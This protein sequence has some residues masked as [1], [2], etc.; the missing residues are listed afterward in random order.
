MELCT[1][2]GSP[3]A[4]SYL[5]LAE[6]DD[7]MP[8]HDPNW[9]NRNDTEKIILIRRAAADV[10]KVPCLGTKLSFGQSLE[11][12]RKGDVLV[13]SL[14]YDAGFSRSM[15]TTEVVAY[16]DHVTGATTT[17]VDGANYA[18]YLLIHPEWQASPDVRRSVMVIQQR[19][20]DAYLREF[21]AREKKFKYT[22][23]AQVDEFGNVISPP[24]VGETW[25]FVWDE[26][27][28]H[29]PGSDPVPM[30]MP[31]EMPTLQ[32]D[33]NTYTFR[34]IAVPGAGFDPTSTDYTVN[35]VYQTET[36]E[37]KEIPDPSHVICSELAV[38]DRTDILPDYFK[39]AALHV[40]NG[41]ERRYYNVLSCDVTTGELTLD[42]E[43]PA[44]WAEASLS[45]IYIDPLHDAIKEAQKVQ[46]RARSS[47]GDIA[48][49]PFAGMGLA[50]IKIGD[51]SRSYATS[52]GSFSAMST[53]AG[54]L[55]VNVLTLTILG[56]YSVYGKVSIGWQQ[57]IED[58]LA[59][60]YEGMT[61]T[62]EEDTEG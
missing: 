25:R 32:F 11:W 54:R 52:G 55:G 62:A 61:E 23:P 58:T 60:G 17:R 24:T 42:G 28:E 50:S 8:L 16:D 5:T 22:A 18:E 59:D 4:N 19:I 7:F 37:V 13:E 48:V 53:I 35:A 12:P 39:G 1:V 15:I 47:T 29:M 56:K 2:L 57:R 46:L 36:T 3:K 38:A 30:T 31:A 43:I 44:E 14:T 45:F 20:G 51:T 49:D 27:R 41:S 34:M 40:I 10:D 6:A 33:Y 9:L 21:I 26:Y